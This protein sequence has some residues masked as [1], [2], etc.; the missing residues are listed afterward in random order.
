MEGTEKKIGTP[1]SLEADQPPHPWISDVDAGERTSLDP[2][3]DSLL[4]DKGN[5]DKDS[6]MPNLPVPKSQRADPRR[7]ME[8]ASSDSNQGRYCLRPRAGGFN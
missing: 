1:P 2:V 8:Q 6:E 3:R 7:K 4:D 5:F